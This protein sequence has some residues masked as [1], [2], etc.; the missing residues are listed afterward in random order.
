MRCFKRQPGRE[1]LK[2][3]ITELYVSVFRFAME[4]FGEIV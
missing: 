2:P 1:N 3:Y 4:D